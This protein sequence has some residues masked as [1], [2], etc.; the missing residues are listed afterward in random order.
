MLNNV[1]LGILIALKLFDAWSTNYILSRGGI[2][3]NPILAKLIH[4]FGLEAGIVIDLAIVLGCGFVA[5]QYSWEYLG[6]IVVWYTYW[7]VVQY[8]QVKLSKGA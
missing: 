7:M 6:G 5:Y 1:L 4:M 3:R 8:K 2:E